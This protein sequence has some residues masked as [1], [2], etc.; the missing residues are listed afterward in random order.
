MPLESGPYQREDGRWAWRLVSNGNII[1][2]D[3]GQ[4]YENRD[5]AAEMYEKVV[6]GVYGA[7]LFD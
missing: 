2:T 7:G 1:A 5:D 3:G 6:S 4:G